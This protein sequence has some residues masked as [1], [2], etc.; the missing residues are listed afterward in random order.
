MNELIRKLISKLIIKVFADEEEGDYPSTG[1]K[2]FI[3]RK[4]AYDG[5]TSIPS[6]SVKPSIP[7]PSPQTKKQATEEKPRNK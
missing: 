4:T 5:S 2:I 3:P 6:T 1:A 7:K